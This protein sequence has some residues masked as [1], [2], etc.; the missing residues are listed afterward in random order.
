MKKTHCI[1][2]AGLLAVSLATPLQSAAD[3]A[4]IIGVYEN[5]RPVSS[6]IIVNDQIEQA[7]RIV[8][9]AE[10]AGIGRAFDQA[11]P[12]MIASLEGN[13]VKDINVQR[14]GA[15]SEGVS[16]QFVE[17][18]VGYCGEKISRA[19]ILVDGNLFFSRSGTEVDF[20]TFTDEARDKLRSIGITD[21]PR[22]SLSSNVDC[23]QDSST[24]Q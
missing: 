21:E 17:A 20:E 4:T 12:L 2:G 8:A 16:G 7:H 6:T 3:E 14:R 22:V 15:C 9:Q 24:Q 10:A 5:C 19:E 11:L 1:I 13:G 18:I 23:G